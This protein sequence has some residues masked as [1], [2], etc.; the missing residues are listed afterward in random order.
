MTVLSVASAAGPSTAEA[1][2][3]VNVSVS[4]RLCPFLSTMSDPVLI[5]LR[6]PGTAFYLARPW[7]SAATCLPAWQALQA[8]GWRARKCYS[9]R[10]EIQAL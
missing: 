5:S 1:A 3:G 4:L 2:E 6:N 10:Q 9:Q 7:G 8:E